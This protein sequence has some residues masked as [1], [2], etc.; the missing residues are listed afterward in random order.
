[1]V[2]RFSL[3]FNIFSFEVFFSKI[4]YNSVQTDEIKPGFLTFQG[5]IRIAL[6]FVILIYEISTGAFS[7]IFR[8]SKIEKPETKPEKRYNQSKIEEHFCDRIIKLA[9]FDQLPI[10]YLNSFPGSGNT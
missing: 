5:I 9:D 4:L 2:F 8:K 1:M 6:C 3:P 10:I 7:G